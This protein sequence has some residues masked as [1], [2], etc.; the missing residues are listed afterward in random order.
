MIKFGVCPE[1]NALSTLLLLVT[2]ILVGVF[3]RPT[4]QGGIRAH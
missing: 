3:F 2:F 4:K 1:I